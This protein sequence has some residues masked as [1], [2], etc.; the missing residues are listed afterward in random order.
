MSISLKA[1]VLVVCIDYIKE[2]DRSSV[3]STTG[4]LGF[5]T[6][7]QFDGTRIPYFSYP[8]LP[9]VA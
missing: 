1:H 4:V 5:G 3:M 6:N 8:N 7:S 2:L 9:T